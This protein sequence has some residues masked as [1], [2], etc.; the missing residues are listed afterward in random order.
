MVLSRLA[1]ADLADFQHYRHDDVVGRYQRWLPK[2]DAEATALLEK[3]S[4]AE[5][6]SYSLQSGAIL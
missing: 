5:F 3:Y 2:T 4:E 1:P 6:R